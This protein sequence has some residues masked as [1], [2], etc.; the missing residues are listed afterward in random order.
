MQKLR[1]FVPPEVE[2]THI[3]DKYTVGDKDEDWIPRLGTEG[4]WIV[5]TSDAGRNS[6]KGQK[7]PELCLIHRV[8]HVI[9]SGTLN[10]MPTLEKIKSIATAWAFFEDVFSSPPGSRYFMRLKTQR[11]NQGQ[12]GKQSLTVSV[13]PCKVIAELLTSFRPEDTPADAV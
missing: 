8:T 11:G 13:D 7:L 6:K 4:G 9:L 2:L 12:K 5:I 1:D 3:I 10:Q